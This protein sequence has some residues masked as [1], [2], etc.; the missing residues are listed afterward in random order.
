ML[1]LEGLVGLHRTNKFN[2][3]FF[4]ITGQS[5]DLDYCDGVHFGSLI[6]IMSMFTLAISYLTTFNLPWFMGFPLS[7]S[8]IHL[9]CR[10]ARFGSWAGKIHCRRDRLPIPVFW[11][12]KYHGL[13]SPW[14]SK[15]LYVN[16]RVLHGPNIPGFYAILFFISLDFTSITGHIH[17]WVL[18]LLWLCLFILSEVISL[19][20]SS[21]ILGT[22]WPGKFI[23]QC[24][25]FFSLLYNSWG[26]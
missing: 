20:F 2:F 8:R 11:P 22:Y 1:V 23:F 15:E 18:F 16:E 4:S 26:S 25:I 9:Q 5:I 19:L 24:P 12:G 6:P 13:Y 10:R 21:S 17:N 7:W 14:G 3:N